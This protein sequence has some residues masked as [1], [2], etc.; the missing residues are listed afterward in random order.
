MERKNVLVTGGTGYI[1]SHTIIDLISHGYTPISV[2]NGMNSDKSSLDKIFE[3]TGNKIK[4]YD[5]DL[6]D[7][8]ASKQIFDENKIDAVIHFAALKAV[9]ESVE[10]PFLYFKNNI[11]SLLNVLQLSIENN[12]G[13]FVFS[14]SCTVYGDVRKS[15]VDEN[16]PLQEA[17]SPYGRTKQ[18]GEQIIH[19]CL[20]RN[21]IKASILRYFNPAGAHTSAKI[22]ESPVNV[23]QNLVPV[24]TETAIGK[25][26]K[27]KVFGDDYNTKDGSCV[28]DYI[29]VMD[30]AAAHTLAI[31]RALNDESEQIEI[32]NLGSGSGYTVLEVIAS[33]EK[34]SGKKLNYELAERRP[35]DIE[36]IYSDYQLAKK[37]L[38]WQPKLNIEDIMK[39]AWAWEQK[40]SQ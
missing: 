8:E 31:K 30:L 38:K 36:A 14:S 27:M 9:G 18:M 26:S 32:Y 1:G 5:I 13:A 12:V 29:H 17:A 24:I 3:I 2:D 23:A 11:N 35:G 22:G 40:R 37:Q 21:D 34:A 20:Q 16:T 39:T 33:F 6:T 15:P 25:R 19:D 10:K 7:F 28:R 4:H